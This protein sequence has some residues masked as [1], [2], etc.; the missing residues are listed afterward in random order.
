MSVRNL[1]II[2]ENPDEVIDY[3]VMVGAKEMR[4]FILTGIK[5]TGPKLN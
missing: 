1:V 4:N 2:C 3:L 5:K